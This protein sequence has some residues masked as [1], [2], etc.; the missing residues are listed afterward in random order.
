MCSGRV[1][2]SCSTSG[3]RRVNLVTNPVISREC[4][5]D[6]E[7]FV[8]SGSYPWSFVT[9]IFYS[10]QPSHKRYKKH[11]LQFYESSFLLL[12][13]SLVYFFIFLFVYSQEH[14][15][16]IS[17][18]PPPFSLLP[19]PFSKCSYKSFFFQNF[20]NHSFFFI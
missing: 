19:P 10:G 20:H 14:G 2:S 7:V 15:A 1:S 11:G 5:K 6:L 8:T 12:Y 4:G 13:V 9:Q 3:T 18:P 16:C 17:F